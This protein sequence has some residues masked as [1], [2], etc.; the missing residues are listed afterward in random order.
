MKVE[1]PRIYENQDMAVN[2]RSDEQ[3]HQHQIGD[4]I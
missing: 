4:C 1:G 3:M 2:G